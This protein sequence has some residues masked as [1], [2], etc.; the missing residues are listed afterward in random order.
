[1]TTAGYEPNRRAMLIR[2][3]GDVGSAVAHVLFT[4]GYPTTV[5]DAERPAAPRRGMAFADA[6]FAGRTVL[7]GVLAERVDDIPQLLEVMAARSAVAVTAMTFDRLLGAVPWHALIDARMRKRAAPE[8]MRGQA[9]LTI[10][11]GPNFMAN[12]TVDVAIETSWDRLGQV[13]WSGPTLPLAGEPRAI[14]GVARERF[15][16]APTGGMF[17]TRARIGQLVQAG[18]P[19]ASLG[20]L[21]LRAPIAGMIR[22]LTHDVV[23][24]AR[25]T[26]VI[27]I[28][29]RGERAQVR[30]LGE[31]PRRIADAVLSVLRAGSVSPP[32]VAPP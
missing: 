22:G 28:D 13:V 18:D 10:G 5:H 1:M 20:E 31:R 26:K 7:D 27:E 29:P 8:A 25:G 24:V 4:A 16:Y 2:G 19:V 21:P 3:S 14:S 9:P 12:A 32:A 6:L 23:P 11:L 15:V 17:R 30:G